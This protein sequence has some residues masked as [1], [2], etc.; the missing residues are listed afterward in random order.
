MSVIKHRIQLSVEIKPA[1]TQIYFC[2]IYGKQEV[3]GIEAQVRSQFPDFV[4]EDH[5]RFVEFV[6]KY[7]EWMQNR[8]NAL[9]YSHKIKDYQDIDT[10][11]VEFTEQ[12]FKEF[13]PNIPRDIIVNKTQL[14]K[15]IKQFYR[16]KGTEKSFKLFFRML[17]N[18]NVDF[19][20][21]RVDILKVSDGK[22]IQNKTIRVF[23]T[24]GSGENFQARRIRGLSTNSSA[25]VER[26]LLIKEGSF[27]GYEL[28]LNRSS[29]TGPFLPN[30]IVQ[31]EDSVYDTDDA[32]RESRE[33]AGKISPVPSTITINRGG[34]GFQAGQKFTINR[35]GIG[36]EVVVDKVDSSGA[37]VKMSIKRYGLGYNLEFPL[38]DITL[39]SNVE[40]ANISV[41]LGA[42]I[43]YPGY[44]L[45]EDGHI[46]TTKYLHDGEYYQQFSYVLYVSETVSKFKDALK[47]LIHPAGFKMF[48]GFRSQELIDA[49]SKAGRKTRDIIRTMHSQIVRAKPKIHFNLTARHEITRLPKTAPLGPTRRSIYRDRFQYKPYAIRPELDIQ[50]TSFWANVDKEI[51]VGINRTEYYFGSRDDLSNQKAI[52]PISIFGN[53]GLTPRNIEQELFQRTNI[54]PDAVVKCESTNITIEILSFDNVVNV[55]DTISI[56]FNIVNNTSQTCKIVEFANDTKIQI[57]DAQPGINTMAWVYS[58]D[59]KTTDN[60]TV[61][62][63]CIVDN[64][65]STYKSDDLVVTVN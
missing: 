36:A 56:V 27:S 13:L 16:A 52:T 53:R 51:P 32:R 18:I 29:V 8:G 10:T 7:Y 1:D 61:L 25:F 34:K 2:S 4:Q 64:N 11:V 23:V 45:N 59:A 41:T 5:T 33:V 48:G 30:E 6:E 19:Y 63:I 15:H 47:R 37:I 44:Y 40:N 9:H 12:F 57:L 38:S 35:E 24:K 39:L 62:S 42:S 50:P 65:G 60:K 54:L 22:W 43:D 26:V 46:S 55:G 31:A 58:Y 49:R 3:P 21:P 20:Y 28:V 14:L 17:Y